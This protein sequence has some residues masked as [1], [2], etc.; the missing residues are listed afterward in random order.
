MT[1]TI[2][3]LILAMLLLPATGAVFLLS[4]VALIR[5]NGQ[6]SVMRLLVVW[7]IVYSF[8]GIYWLAL[9]WRTVRWT[10]GRLAQTAVATVIALGIGVMVASLC[11]IVG[12]GIPVQ[13]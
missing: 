2:A 10:A 7:F 9:W 5:T 12:R 6:P 1:S 11:F 3:R 13:I 8:V 4:F